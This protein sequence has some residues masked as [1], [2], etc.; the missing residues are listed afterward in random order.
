MRNKWSETSEVE[1]KKKRKERKRKE[2]KKEGMHSSGIVPSS[3]EYWANK[4]RPKCHVT[5]TAW[6][7]DL[8]HKMTHAS[9]S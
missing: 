7:A 2:E 8:P 4:T 5:L 6:L 3:K 9:S 1:K